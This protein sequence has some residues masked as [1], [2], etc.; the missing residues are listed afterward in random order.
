M[1][2]DSF[3]LTIEDCR[4]NYSVPTSLAVKLNLLFWRLFNHG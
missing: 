2:L 3:N 1:I 4:D